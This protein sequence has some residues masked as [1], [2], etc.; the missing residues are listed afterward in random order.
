[1]RAALIE[2]YRT[3]RGS[4]RLRARWET[5]DLGR[6]GWQ[7]V[8]TEIPYAVQKSRLIEKIADL[9]Q[10]KKLPLLGDVRDESAEDVRL[11]LEPKSRNVEP[12]LLMEQLFRLTELEARIPLNMTVLIR[13]KVP[14]VLGLTQV[15][16][17]WLDHRKVVLRRR[18]EHRLRKIE[19]RLEVL[20]GLLVA[21]L[22]IDEVIRIIR[23]EDEPKL[24][25]MSRFSLTDV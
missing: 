19:H 22:N 15:L 2:A 18:S 17:E 13:G 7:I 24:V 5:E 9:L 10:A 20:D 12:A 1:D 11:V 14:Q 23:N 8:V 21:Y 16:Q 6:G 3:G 4:F 25:L